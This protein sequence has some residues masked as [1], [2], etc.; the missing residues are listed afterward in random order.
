M[1]PKAPIVSVNPQTLAQAAALLSDGQLCA[2]PTETVYGLGADATNAEAVLRIY[3][4]KGRPSY[5]PLIVHVPDAQ[6][7]QQLVTEWSPQAN[8]L[9]QRFWPGPLSLVLPRGP[10]I[11]DIVSAGLPTVALRVPSHPVALALLQTVRRPL[12]AP[13]ANRSESLSPTTAQHVQRSLPNVPL[14]LDGGPCL[15]GIES[16]VVDLTTQPPRLL[17]PGALPLRLL[18]E[19]L[20]DLQLPSFAIEQPTG[21]HPSP[22]MM[23]RHYAPSAPLHLIDESQADWVA[24]LPEPRGLVTHRQLPSVTPL[25]QHLELLPSSP[26]AYAADLYAALHRLDD[27]Q[28]RSI[29]V[30]RPS[31]DNDWRAILD[32]LGRAAAR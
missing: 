22:G 10:H 31:Q 30:L 13:S 18:L 21:A 3:Q 8:R 14:I 5:N 12:A 23:T 4:L 7:A 27:Q 29:V 20:P 19:E 24:S 9:A 2:F 26:E 32:R 17:R 15:L 16:T 6:S 1:I 28:V 25:C 11:P